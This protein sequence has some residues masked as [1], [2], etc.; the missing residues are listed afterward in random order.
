MFSCPIKDLTVEWIHSEEA[1]SISKVHQHVWLKNNTAILYDN[2]IP[3]TERD[4]KVLD[5]EK[6]DVLASLLDNKKA[7]ENLNQILSDSLTGLDWPVS[8][9]SNGEKAIY[10]FNGDIFILEIKYYPLGKLTIQSKKKS[11]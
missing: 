3:I 8:F 2:R 11:Q 9:D 4:F 5:P 7:V 6:P 10:I 1:K